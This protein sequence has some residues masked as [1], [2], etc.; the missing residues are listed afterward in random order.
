[1]K[2]DIIPVC[3]VHNRFQTRNGRW[4]D[5]SFGELEKHKEFCCVDNVTELETPCDLCD[6][7]DQLE[8]DFRQAS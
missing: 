5:N 6:D 4:I 8:I 2:R 3:T 7:P 1:M